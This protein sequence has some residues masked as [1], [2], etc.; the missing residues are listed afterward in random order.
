MRVA[1]LVGLLMVPFLGAQTVDNLI[2]QSE[3]FPPYNFTEGGELRGTSI[4]ILAEVLTALH[5]RLTVGDVKVLPWARSYRELLET[6]NTVLFAM[7]R[8]ADRET[9]F[10]WAGPITS[11][12]NVLIGRNN[13]TFAVTSVAQAAGYRVG[14]IRDDA[15]EQLLLS[16]GFPAK[17]LQYAPGAINLLKMLLADRVD[18]VAYDENVLRWLW[19]H[20]P[21]LQAQ[22]QLK[23]FVVLAAG[24]HYF[25]FNRR[26]PDSVVQQ[27]QKALD[28]LKAKGTFAQIVSGYLK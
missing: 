14:V 25:G 5:S 26:T 10:K 20:D 7:T 1:L 15:G 3:D 4:E 27:F 6:P 13:A 17:D 16:K 8:T 12:K 18:F 22:G 19:S 11:A 21:S 23:T 24:S 2:L 9:L 28:D